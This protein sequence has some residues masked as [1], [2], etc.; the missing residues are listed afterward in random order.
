MKGDMYYS[1]KVLLIRICVVYVDQIVFC[2]KD[3]F[4]GVC[5]YMLA[6]TLNVSQG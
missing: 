3:L 4:N 1:D 2:L 5:V 6:A